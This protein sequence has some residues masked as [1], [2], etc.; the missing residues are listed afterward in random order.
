[1]GRKICEVEVNREKEEWRE[2]KGRR[3]RRGGRKG[4][5]GRVGKYPIKSFQVHLVAMVSQ[6]HMKLLKT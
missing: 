3:E 6:S 1:M 5:E 4:K 2:G